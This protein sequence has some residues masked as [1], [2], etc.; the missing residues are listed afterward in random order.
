MSAPRVLIVH[1][2]VSVAR[3]F[4]DYPY[5]ANLGAVQLA[6]VLREGGLAD[7]AL[8]DAYALAGSTLAWRP[9]GRA[10]LGAPLGDVLAHVRACEAA[11]GASDVVVV[12]Y[13]PFHRPPA[14]DDL[15]GELLAG[16]RAA[17]PD[18]ALVLA[19]CYQS[20]Q[21]YIEADGD[22]VLASYPEA[23][24]WVKYEAEVTLPALVRA[25]GER[26]ERP[27]GTH[28][29]V[30]PPAL[31]ALPFPAW[32]L[33]DLAA[34]QRFHARVVANLGRGAWAFPIDGRTLP[35]VTSRGC[36]FVCV[37]CSSN[38]GRAPGAPK[39]QRRYSPERLRAYL[40]TLV[41]AHGATR[42][43]VLDEL[44]NVNERHWDTFLDEIAALDTRFDVPNGMRADY[45]EPEHFAKMRGRVT[46][47]SV[48]AES[49]V[50]RVVT[51]VVRKRLDLAAIRRA[52]ES[53]HA[54][55]VPLMV[56]YMIGLPGETAEEINGTLAFAMDLWDRF[57]AFP[58]VQ[59]ATPLPGTQLAR[60]RTL[61]VV[62]DWGPLFQTAPSQPDAL[63]SE[64]QLRKF[65]WTFDERLRASQGPRKVIMN[66]TYVCNNHC[67]FCAVGTRTQVDGHPVRQREHLDK[68]RALGVRM[69]DFDG[70]E[71][72]M[73]PELIPLV[74]YARSIGYERINVTTNGRLC[75]Y[76][77]FARRLVRSGLTT[78]L[79]SV[80]GP[81][82]QS[83]AQQVGVAEAF[84]Q[85]TS[86]IRHCLKHAPPGVELGMNITVTKGNFTKLEAVAQLAWDLGLRWLNIQ[87]LTP[88][89][90]AT[91]WVAPDTQAAA[92]IARGVIDRW[93]DRMKFQVINLPFCFM[94]GYEQYMMGDL[95]KLQ[96]HMIF[97]NNEDVNLADYLAERR[98]R[99][100]VCATCPH[101]VFCG[102][103]YELEAAPE[104]PWLVRPEDLVRPVSRAP[105][106]R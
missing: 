62:S 20:G 49:G 40:R 14:R 45:L 23:D 60:G 66:V 10:H 12:A 67:T 85:T 9:D 1:P 91:K 41:H 39:T 35:L 90:R 51:E 13:T 5:F 68:Y 79:F 64:E 18:T 80:H 102:G 3:D 52:A 98:T 71:P 104:P 15:L 65:K 50:Q 95:L 77:D 88:F 37:H 46:T 21:H 58:A 105:A 19:D 106:P 96:R 31:D 11:R 93:K 83:H 75:H 34:Y 30:E 100:P 38:P 47:V 57:R 16:L 48:S 101:A 26:G 33:V 84:E 103:F 69:V 56:H 73:N 54:A 82:A 53:A 28:R 44:V 22:A 29:G 32:D 25:L 8:V 87:F 78:L 55:G 59:F 43:E 99:K 70:G 61:P 97:V 94:P 42:L 81:D 4:I 86:G 2:P 6:A 24:A 63:V 27:R 17:A 72:T 7:V 36:P 92:D 76:E 74:R 89:G